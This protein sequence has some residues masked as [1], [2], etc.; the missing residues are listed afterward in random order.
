MRHVCQVDRLQGDA[1]ERMA[2]ALLS[3]HPEFRRLPSGHWA[4]SATAVVTAAD[5]AP[6]GLLAGV[7]LP[8]TT[9]T[10]AKPV[11]KAQAR[12]S[13]KKTVKVV[14]PPATIFDQLF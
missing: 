4:L 14:K 5:A 13:Y 12:R 8:T 1:A 10:D 9:V 2:L 3:S 11:K 6:T 7:K